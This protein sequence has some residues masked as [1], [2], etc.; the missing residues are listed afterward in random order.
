MGPQ[1]VGANPSFVLGAPGNG[2]SWLEHLCWETHRARTL[3]PARLARSRD[4]DLALAQA[5]S[6]WPSG[7]RPRDLAQGAEETPHWALGKGNHWGIQQ[8]ETTRAVQSDCGTHPNSEAQTQPP[9]GGTRNMQ[10]SHWKGQRLLLPA[11]DA[12]SDGVAGSDRTPLAP[13]G[14]AQLRPATAIQEKLCR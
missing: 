13:A 10:Q 14:R 7:V 9:A 11:R 8:R 3:I 1:R 6:Y 4:P 12:C 2:I 5:A